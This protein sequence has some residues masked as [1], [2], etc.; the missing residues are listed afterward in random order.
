[1][2]PQAQAELLDKLA[3]TI[4]EGIS[5]TDALFILTPFYLSSDKV[6]E[7]KRLFE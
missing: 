6:D 1:M 2:H 3:V 7:L 5:S 4:E